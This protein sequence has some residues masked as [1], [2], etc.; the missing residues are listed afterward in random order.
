M[1]S[2]TVTIS[3]KTLNTKSSVFK[4]MEIHNKYL[5]VENIY[6]LGKIAYD[7]SWY[8]VFYGSYHMSL[9]KIIDENKSA[10]IKKIPTKIVDFVRETIALFRS[11]EL[12]EKYTKMDFD[13]LLKKSLIF[14]LVS[15]KLMA[16][17]YLVYKL[18]IPYT[19]IR[20]LMMSYEKDINSIFED[21]TDLVYGRKMSVNIV[22][23]S[24]SFDAEIGEH[25]AIAYQVAGV[26][27]PIL[28]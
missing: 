19:N 17:N 6:K 16:D 23:P 18:F 10:C 12:D 26:E 13:N 20:Y 24:C 4:D 21:I 9:A 2:T 7:Y 8:S 14:N 11:I 22:Y 25:K 27:P 1:S 5:H 3:N 28:A 15:K